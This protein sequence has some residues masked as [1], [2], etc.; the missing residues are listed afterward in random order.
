MILL[1]LVLGC[2]PKATI[3]RAQGEVET[4]DYAWHYVQDAVPEGQVDPI[5]WQR[6]YDERYLRFRSLYPAIKGVT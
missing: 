5:A 4:F 1:A 6:V 2:A 3:P